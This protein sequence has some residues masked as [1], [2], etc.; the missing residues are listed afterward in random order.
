MSGPSENPHLPLLGTP[1]HHRAWVVPAG[2][3]KDGVNTVEIE[4]LQGG[5]VHADRAPRCGS[6][7]KIDPMP[8]LWQAGA[9]VA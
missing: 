8:N 6:A 5:Q 7:V 2:V 4:L 1:E 3:T 9:P